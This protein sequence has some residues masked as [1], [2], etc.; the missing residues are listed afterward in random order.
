MKK[1]EQKQEK[2][3]GMNE[4]LPGNFVNYLLSS[5]VD[6]DEIKHIR[7]NFCGSSPKW[8]EYSFTD[9][10]FFIKKHICPSCQELGEQIE[11][12]ALSA[13]QN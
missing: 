8:E 13:I 11:K 10:V 2:N 7:C 4:K 5:Q 9:T 1:L 3:F 12:E 6:Y